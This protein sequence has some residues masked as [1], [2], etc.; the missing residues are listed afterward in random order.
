MISDLTDLVP[1]HNKVTHHF[2][3]GSAVVLIQVVENE[4]FDTVSH[5]KFLWKI[6]GMINIKR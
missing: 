4:T 3:K 6:K 2:A 1:S 5:R